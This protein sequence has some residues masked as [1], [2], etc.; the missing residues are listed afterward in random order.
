MN[1]TRGLAAVLALLAATTTLTGCASMVRSEAATACK[2]LSDVL[3]RSDRSERRDEILAYIESGGYV[4]A[5]MNERIWT[6]FDG[7]AEDLAAV[8]SPAAVRG[9]QSALVDSVQEVVRTGRQLTVAVSTNSLHWST[10]WSA[11]AN[12]GDGTAKLPPWQ[13]TA[14]LD[15]VDQMVNAGFELDDTCSAITDG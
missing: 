5:A 15:A 3:N 8:D 14:L 11:V 2:D 13:A 7:L 9:D 6:E 1:R 10:D 4:G 12:G